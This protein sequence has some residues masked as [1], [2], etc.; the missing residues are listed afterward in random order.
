MSHVK[1]QNWLLPVKNRRTSWN[2][3]MWLVWV[4]F[5]RQW[6]VIR[7]KLPIKHIMMYKCDCKQ[8]QHTYSIWVW[9]SSSNVFSLF[10]ISFLSFMMFRLQLL[11][12]RIRN[13]LVNQLGNY[14]EWTLK[15]LRYS[16][17]SPHSTKIF[18]IPANDR[19]I[20]WRFLG[21]VLEWDSQQHQRY[22]RPGYSWRYTHL[23]GGI[24]CQLYDTNLQGLFCHVT[25]H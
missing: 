9:K 10:V 15:S 12:I 7:S 11:V 21:S 5:S 25:D 20:R 16:I 23:A 14:L 24:T 13:F 2:I 19:H 22:I 8:C 3:I 18:Q 6:K 17:Q 4:S 1:C